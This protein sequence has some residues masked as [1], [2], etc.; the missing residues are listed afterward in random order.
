MVAFDRRRVARAASS[1]T[2]STPT[3][4]R[5]AVRMVVDEDRADHVDLNFGCP[6]PKV[7]RKGGGAALPCKR[8]LLRRD[9]RAA[10]EAADGRVPVT[11][12][13]RMGI[14]D[15]HLTY[16]DAGP[17]RR[18]TPASPRSR[19]T[20]ARPR[21][22]YSGAGRLGRD[23]ASSRSRARRPGARQRRHLGGRR[24]AA[25]DARDRLR[26]RRRRPW[27]PRP[28]V[29]V[30]RPRR[31][32]RRRAG[33]AAP[34]ALGEVAATCAGTP[35]C[36]SS[37]CGEDAGCR[38]FRKHVAWYL[39]GFRGRRSSVRQRARP[40][41][42]RWPSSTSCSA[43]LDLDQPFPRQ[44]LGRPRGRRRAAATRGAA[45]RLAATTATRAAVDPA[46]ELGV[47]GG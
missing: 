16:L 22:C 24:R 23:R 19:C 38:D 45:R 31:R 37:G 42:A 2:A 6:V 13:M 43:A 46:A 8:R 33:R 21:S 40:G 9:R 36:W 26:R 1:S 7:T 28:A 10:V 14:D 34:P 32:L 11:M 47:S 3:S 39:K 18:R 35:S 29:A 20:R 25:D 30:R 44:V 4:S 15:D 17:D 27:L 5:D 12:K 41:R